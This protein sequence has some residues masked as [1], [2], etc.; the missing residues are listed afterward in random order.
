MYS[1]ILKCIQTEIDKFWAQ[2]EPRNIRI[3]LEGEVV[4]EVNSQTW[5]KTKQIE[6]LSE[7]SFEK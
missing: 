6:A 2:V 1:Q 4:V 7:S 3:G 5:G